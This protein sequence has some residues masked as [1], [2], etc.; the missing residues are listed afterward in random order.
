MKMYIVSLGVGLLVGVIYGVLNVRSPAPPV[1]ALV[2]LLG[3]SLGE[4]LIPLAKR[5]I[6]NE[7][8]STAWAREHCVPHSFGQLPGISAET[9]PPKKIDVPTNTN[10][11]GDIE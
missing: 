7:P 1:I 5:V 3:I 2:G 9:V 6:S 11:R 8:V 10:L 4:Q